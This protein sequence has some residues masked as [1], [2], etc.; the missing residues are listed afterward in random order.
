MGKMLNFLFVKV[1]SIYNY[2][3][4]KNSNGN[5]TFIAK[6]QYGYPLLLTSKLN[7]F[8]FISQRCSMSQA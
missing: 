3:L 2:Q 6:L 1:G 7:I 5:Q 8:I 4:S